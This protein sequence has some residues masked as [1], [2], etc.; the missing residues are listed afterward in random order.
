M[1]SSQTS[2]LNF[3]FQIRY[4]MNEFDL[5][6]PQ[7]AFRFFFEL[8]STPFILPCN[9]DPTQTSLHLNRLYTEIRNANLAG[10]TNT[11]KNRNKPE[12]NGPNAALPDI[13]MSHPFDDQSTIR[14]LSDAG[15]HLILELVVP[16]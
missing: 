12:R 8:H 6:S 10:F 7:R 16:S 5:K 9:F 13:D 15:Y 3:F 4:Y 11:K 14:R 2:Q 1:L